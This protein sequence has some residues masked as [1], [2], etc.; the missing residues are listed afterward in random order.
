MLGCTYRQA[1]D[2]YRI[3]HATHL[4]PECELEI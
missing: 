2:L 4:E 3:S 1:A